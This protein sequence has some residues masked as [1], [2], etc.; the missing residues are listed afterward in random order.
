MNVLTCLLDVDRERTEYLGRRY[1]CIVIDEDWIV[2]CVRT[3]VFHNVKDEPC[4][5]LCTRILASGRSSQQ[6]LFVRFS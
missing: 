2:G 1:L 5:T 4:E 6:K 3:V